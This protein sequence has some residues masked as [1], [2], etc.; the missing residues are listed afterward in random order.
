MKIDIEE[1]SK[2]KRIFKIE[3]PSDVVSK[4]YSEAYDNVRKNAKVPGF[5]KGKLP[6]AVI[7]RRFKDDVESEIIKKLVPEYYFKAIKE[8]GVTPVDMPSID[9]VEV[10]K[11][12]P[13]TF[14][15]TVEIRP[16]IGSVDYGG[17][18]LKKEE[19]TVTDE[20]VA[21]GIEE[22][23]ERNAQLEI[24]DEGH[25]IAK[26]DHIRVDYEG[27][28]GGKPVKELKKEGVEFQTGAEMVAPEID[29]GLIGA[30]PGEEREIKIPEGDVLFKVRITEVKKKVLPEI[31]DDLAKDAGEGETLAVL[32]EKV[33]ERV[34]VRKEDELRSQYRN[35]VI[36]KLIELNPV[37]LPPSLVEKEMRNFLSRTKK[38]MGKKDN[39]EPDEEK[40]LREKYTSHAEELV[41]SGLLLT[42]IAEIEGINAT[43]EDADAEIKR[44]AAK[45][46]QDEVL[47]RRYISSVEGGMDNMKDKIREDKVIAHILEKVKWT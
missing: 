25:A 34:R 46:Q 5:R 11:G 44:M 8:S 7:E 16:K 45:S 15:A 32:K 18:E 27:F 12:S 22:I 33:R 40:A 43:D 42:A 19:S 28:A 20:D 30:H 17:I 2:I 37:D 10:K 9:N 41:K 14:T 47:I 35:S 4:E 1:V 26:G 39:F 29:N 6:A 36:K 3:V 21:A 24:C 23:R 38:F 31:N 13:L